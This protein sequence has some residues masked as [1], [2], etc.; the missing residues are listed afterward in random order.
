MG[1]VLSGQ[2]L[3]TRPG[4]RFKQ[5]MRLPV[6]I[7][8]AADLFPDF[9][10]AALPLLYR[11]NR[12][13]STCIRR[14]DTAFPDRRVRIAQCRVIPEQQS[15][16]TLNFAGDGTTALGRIIAEFNLAQVTIHLIE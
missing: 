9:D 14:L 16:H 10:R 3:T 2:Q 1:S 12:R 7:R 13:Q 5:R 15:G 8:R 11:L 4:C 6:Q